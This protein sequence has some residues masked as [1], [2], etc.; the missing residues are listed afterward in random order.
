MKHLSI[1]FLFLA[2][3]SNSQTS[4]CGADKLFTDYENWRLET[5]PSY[6]SSRNH[7]KR[8]DSF[9]QNTEEN[10]AKV[11][12]QKKDFLNRAQKLMNSESCESQK[13]NLSLFH[14]DL[15]ESI[16]GYKYNTRFIEFSSLGGPHTS[17]PQMYKRVPLETKQNYQ[18]YL[19][20]LSKI[21]EVFEQSKTLSRKGM[22]L[23][24]VPPKVTFQ[25]YESSFLDLAKG[26][27]EESSFYKPFK[28]L[29]ESFSEK[30]K[31]ELKSRAKKIISEKVQPAYKDLHQF[32]TKEYYP[33]LREGIAA[34]DL[35]QGEEYYNFQVRKMTTLDVSAKEVHEIGLR[36][37]KRIRSEMEKIAAKKGFKNDLAG[38]FKHLRTSPQYYAKS[39]KDLLE[40]TALILKTIDGK[41]PKLFKELPS[42]P[43]GIEPIPSFIAEKSP[44]AYYNSGRFE[45]G[46][47]GTFQINL[48]D[49]NSRPLYNLVALSL[50]EAVPGHHLQIALAQELKG[51]PE[52]RKNSGPTAFVE[53]W[54]LYA[55]SLGE[56][57]GMYEDPLDDFGRLTYE[58]WRAMRLVVDTG[59]HAFGW[60]R[61]KAIN[62]MKEN[63][64]LSEKNIVAE[65]DRYINWPGQALAYKMGQLKILEL[66]DFSEKELGE[67]FD[68]RDF[69]QVVLGS[70]AIPLPMLEE[71]V[72]EYVKKM[73]TPQ[74][75]QG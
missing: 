48:S 42:L 18:D 63:S 24:M 37:V 20:R 52:F 1:I 72:K 61:E 2:A 13:T 65:V 15:K 51:L 19:T 73:R 27:V 35:P 69:H 3:C 43:Y 26:E 32:W 75:R 14:Y 59:I 4:G 50:H 5:F 31:E 25:G 21:P 29:P 71:N 30:T 67:K 49:L 6:A 23:K 38:F 12:E 47:S 28:D 68:I 41:L 46:K 10:I 39:E 58:Q 22:K 45:I 54:A 55:E 34:S 9:F 44:A 57:V 60:S 74:K 56:K 66:R 53:G 16:E 40:K 33:N 7:G 36:E 8:H 62:F 17:L 64:G 11:H 70:G